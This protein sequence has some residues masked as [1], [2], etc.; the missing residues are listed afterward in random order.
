MR[1]P[2]EG[3]TVIVNSPNKPRFS[4]GLGKRIGKGGEGIV[5]R[6]DRVGIVVKIFLFNRDTTDKF[7]TKLKLK[8]EKIE[9]MLRTPPVQNVK[10]IAWPE[11]IVYFDGKACGYIMPE[12]SG[13]GTL[14]EACNPVFRYEKFP[15]LDIYLLLLLAENAARNVVKIHQKQHILGDIR[16]LN[17]LFDN[18]LHTHLIDTDNFSIFDRSNNTTYYADAITPEYAPPEFHKNCNVLLTEAHDNFSLAVLFHYLIYGIHPYSG[19]KRI[20]ERDTIKYIKKGD[21]LYDDKL[22]IELTPGDPPFDIVGKQVQELFDRAFLD[23]HQDPSK[24][25]GAQE[26]AEVLNDARYDLVW[27]QEH[28]SHVYDKNCSIYKTHSNPCPWCNMDVLVFPPRNVYQR[29]LSKAYALRH[30]QMI[31]S[32]SQIN[33]T[34]IANAKRVLDANPHFR[35]ISEISSVVEKVVKFEQK[36]NEVSEFFED[37]DV[38]TSH[39]YSNQNVIGWGEHFYENKDLVKLFKL[40]DLASWTE[41][42]EKRERAKNTS[43]NQHYSSNYNELLQQVFKRLSELSGRIDQL[44]NQ[45]SFG[46][47]NLDGLKGDIAKVTN[48]IFYLKKRSFANSS[49]KKN[50]CDIFVSYVHK[51]EYDVAHLCNILTYNGYNVFFAGDLVAGDYYPDVLERKLREADAVIVLWCKDAVK[52]QWVNSEADLARK[53]KTII[54]VMFDQCSLKF[55]HSQLHCLDLSFWFSGGQLPRSEELD[56]LLETVKNK[57]KREVIEDT[58]GLRKY[59]KTFQLRH[60]IIGGGS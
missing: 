1:L 50:K 54:P 40:D 15:Y 28:A 22:K 32:S 56:P 8:I 35:E 33:A 31:T 24:R 13:E 25:P 4:A 3:D 42:N 52:S 5:Y 14:L 57:I 46:E 21:W 44:E 60:R 29:S 17:W 6:T 19:G 38:D 39:D 7:E 58:E 55:P 43:H 47:K 41:L 9:A 18:K 49:V 16:E 53:L 12:I 30:I 27:C 34:N 36:Q 59:S 48:E 45:F 23:G 11:G 2:I 37:L 20:G 10:T 51:R 26:W